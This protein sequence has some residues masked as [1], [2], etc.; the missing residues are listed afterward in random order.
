MG[1]KWKLNGHFQKMLILVEVAVV[2][3]VEVVVVTRVMVVLVVI[4]AVHMMVEWIQIGICS[5]RML[6]VVFRPMV[7][8]DTVHL[9]MV[10]VLPIMAW[11]MV[12]MEVMLAALDMVVLLVQLMVT[13]PLL[14]MEV[15]LRVGLEARG[16]HKLLLD[17]ELWGMVVLLHG[18]LQ[19]LVVVRLVVVLVQ[20]LLVILLVVE[21]DMAI[22]VMGM[23]DMVEVKDLME[24]RAGMVLLEG[25]L[26]VLQTVVLV[27]KCR[28]ALVATWEVVMVM[29]G[30]EMQHGDW[31][32]H[33]LLEI[34]VLSRTVLMVGRLV[35]VV[36]MVVD[37]P[38][39]P[40]SNDLLLT[41]V[42][43][44]SS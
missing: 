7:L 23:L 15:V 18:V 36:V 16:A 26:E 1:S 9:A 12:V 4:Q 5:H 6:E 42:L 40:S 30:M 41:S 25:A 3:A 2:W 39:K 17:M 33:K 35:M 38:A 31:T 28:Q 43:S 19:G 24:I 22:K 29:Q 14:V 37:R 20:R 11:V 34:M 8:L 13:C 21:L 32:H 44:A 27:E 10:M